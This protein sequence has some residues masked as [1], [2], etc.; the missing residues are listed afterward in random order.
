M[1][2]LSRFI[3]S[4]QTKK[5]RQLNGRKLKNDLSNKCVL[6]INKLKRLKRISPVRSN[7][8]ITDQQWNRQTHT[9]FATNNS[10]SSNDLSILWTCRIDF[11]TNIANCANIPLNYLQ[12]CY[13]WRICITLLKW[14][15]LPLKVGNWNDNLNKFVC[16]VNCTLRM[17]LCF[18]AR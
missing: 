7:Q 13:S 8:K 3:Y 15:H 6:I 2:H 18:Q 4:P 10:H 5:L 12:L 16:E 9:I 14:G 11:N 1:K 17:S